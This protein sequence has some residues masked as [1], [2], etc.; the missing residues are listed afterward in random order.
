MT[1]RSLMG[2]RARAR[3][4]PPQPRNWPP[5]IRKGA[6]APQG[7]T[8]DEIEWVPIGEIR[9]GHSRTQTWSRQ[10]AASGSSYPALVLTASNLLTDGHHRYYVLIDGG[11]Q[12]MVPI[13]R[14]KRRS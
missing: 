14:R 3:R 6:V 12:G 11:W 13:V 8:D 9:P 7:R 1:P 10:M 5:W 2:E 4:L